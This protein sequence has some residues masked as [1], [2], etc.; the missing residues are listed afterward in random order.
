[1]RISIKMLY[2]IESFAI[3]SVES[4]SDE[5][6]LINI[7]LKTE[8]VNFDSRPFHCRYDFGDF[9]PL[10]ISFDSETGLLKEITLFV[11]KSCLR[12]DNHDGDIKIQSVTGY[13]CANI[14]FLEKNEFYY[15]EV[16]E[17]NIILKDS[18]LSVFHSDS[19]NCKKVIVNET[20]SLLLDKAETV[21]GVVF[22]NLSSDNLD[23]LN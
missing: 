16:C 10:D 8:S 17:M 5:L 7:E 22:K 20:L 11:N 6:I 19:A 3:R 23:L 15:D 2:N 4:V 18:S 14:D 21:T 12:H 1:M 9:P 13:P